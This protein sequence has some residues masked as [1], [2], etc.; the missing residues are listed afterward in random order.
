M[1]DVLRPCRPARCLLPD[2]TWQHQRFC[3]CLGSDIDAAACSGIDWRWRQQRGAL[4]GNLVH[5]RQHACITIAAG[6]S[7]AQATG[8][9]GNPAAAAG[10]PTASA[11]KHIQKTTRKQLR[12]TL[13]RYATISWPCACV[14]RQRPSSVSTNQAHQ[15]SSK[16]CCFMSA[17]HAG[18]RG[19]RAAACMQATRSRQR[20]A[21]DV[22]C[23]WPCWQPHH[24]PTDRLQ[25]R[26]QQARASAWFTLV[27]KHVASSGSAQRGRAG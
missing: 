19:K 13:L 21:N 8:M 18:A 22:M 4:I 2:A 10:Q 3:S 26:Q 23:A 16:A 7:I 14:T 27:C 6:A 20:T 12:I 24:A 17:C 5:A 11:A 25:A 1:H 9:Q 15:Q